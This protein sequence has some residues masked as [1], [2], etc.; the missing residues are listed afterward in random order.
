M[1]PFYMAKS[2]TNVGHEISYEPEKLSCK[3]LLTNWFHLSYHYRTT[4][5]VLVFV[6]L[7]E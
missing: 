2:M 7:M 4:G 6:L 3:N 1:Q 5:L